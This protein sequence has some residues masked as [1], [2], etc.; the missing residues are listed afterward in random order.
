MESLL[1]STGEAI[2]QANGIDTCSS[3]PNRKIADAAIRK[4]KLT[5]TDLD[6]L[7]QV[8]IQTRGTPCCEQ[9]YQILDQLSIYF[10]IF[11]KNRSF[12]P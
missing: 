10:T 5:M 1:L 6:E 4:S 11:S 3:R 9:W 8:G 2:G 7:E 12:H